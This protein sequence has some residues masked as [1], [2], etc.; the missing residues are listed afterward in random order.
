MEPK[1]SLPHSQLPPTCPYPE[2]ARSSPYAHIPLAEDPSSYYPPFYAWVTQVVPFLQVSPPKSC[3]R[4]SSPHTYYMPRPSHSSTYIIITNIKTL[5]HKFSALH[6]L[7]VLTG[8]S[9]CSAV[10]SAVSG[11]PTVHQIARCANLSTAPWNRHL[12]QKQAFL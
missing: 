9:V 10:N 1:G 5:G 11:H 12:L 7:Q 3:T 2:P 8:V 4:F 6:S